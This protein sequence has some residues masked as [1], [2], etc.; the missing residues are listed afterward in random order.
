MA[1]KIVVVGK[2]NYLSQRILEALLINK[3]RFKVTRVKGKTL[4]QM[5]ENPKAFHKYDIVLNDEIL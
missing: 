5:L 3:E 2:L 1:Q 4:K